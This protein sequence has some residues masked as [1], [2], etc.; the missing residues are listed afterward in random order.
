[1]QDG[2]REQ[3]GNW[4]TILFMLAGLYGDSRQAKWSEAELSLGMARNIKA[5]QAGGGDRNDKGKGRRHQ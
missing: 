1:M 4:F 2:K 3:D 5:G